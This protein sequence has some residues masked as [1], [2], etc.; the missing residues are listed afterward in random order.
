M[1][2]TLSISNRIQH[3]HIEISACNTGDDIPQ[4]HYQVEEIPTRDRAKLASDDHG[5]R[6]P[7]ESVSSS[8]LPHLNSTKFYIYPEISAENNL[9]L[10]PLRLVVGAD[11]QN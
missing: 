5:N 6:T 9:I 3:Q 8:L 1:I 10:S 7:D 4:P 11:V 2:L